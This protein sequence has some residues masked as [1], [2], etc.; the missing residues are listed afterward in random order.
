MKITL[1]GN[2]RMGRQI[3]DIVNR[4]GEHTIFR[5]LDAVDI[6][7]AKAFSGSDVII[8]FT[9]RDAFLLNYKAMIASGVPIVV[10]TTGW[11]DTM[12]RVKAEVAAAGTSM[13]YSANYSLGVNI[14]LRTLREAARLISPF[15]NFD[16][17]LC[18]QHHTGRC[19]DSQPLP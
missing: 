11:D 17:A 13:L 18:E 15:Q 4:T 9:V 6:I 16:I 1:V 12:E 7:D 5:V 10:G 2:G 14:F 19:V 3:T 8:D